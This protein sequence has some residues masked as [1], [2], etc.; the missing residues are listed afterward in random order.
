MSFKDHF[1]SHA[2]AYAAYRPTY[3]AELARWLSTIAPT[4]Q[5][6]LDVGCG[7]GQLSL[8][9]A[10][11]FDRVVATDP[12]R[13]QIDSA[14]LHPKIDYR[15]G[16]AETSGLPDASVDLLTA[17]QAAHWFDQPAFFAE[18]Q[19]VL[20]RNGVIALVTYAGMMP[21][22]DIEKIVDHFRLVT[23]DGYWPPERAIVE[24]DY[25]DIT[26]PFAPIA[27]PPFF[28]EVDWP[29]SALM[30]YLDTWSAVRAMERDI[31]RGPI[32][33]VAKA[34]TG[35]WGDP[36]ITRRICWPLTIVAGRV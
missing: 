16:P 22:G 5:M 26:L 32:E 29:L 1:S 13:Q 19:R 30:G 33:A 3:P 12:S 8:L 15:V 35:A 28:I 31:G 14:I 24:N 21:K 2:A 27:A 4:T 17:A 6:A 7:S 25:S 36:D 23:L 9:L 18:A 10:E 34:L 20:A 11:H